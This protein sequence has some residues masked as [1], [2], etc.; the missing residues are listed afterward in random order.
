MRCC[1][2]FH[3]LLFTPGIKGLL[4]GLN[5][6]GVGDLPSVSF[7]PLMSGTVRFLGLLCSLSALVTWAE[8]GGAGMMSYFLH[9]LLVPDNLESNKHS[10]FTI[11]LLD[12]GKVPLLRDFLG[13][14]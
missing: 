2:L 12:P 8:F 5:L 4:K 3:S 1:P 10:C 11:T 14:S 6:P 9:E 13:N 7:I